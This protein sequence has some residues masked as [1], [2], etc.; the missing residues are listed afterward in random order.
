MNYS[1]ANIIRLLSAIAAFGSAAMAQGS[2][3]EQP[4]SPVVIELFSSQSCSACITAAEYFQELALRD[5]IV[6]L[7]WHVD[8]WNLL[9]TRQGRWE[10]PYSRKEH[11][12]RQKKYN[13]NIRKRSSVYTPQMVVDG[14]FEA[15]GSSREK[16]SALI[17]NAQTNHTTSI[18][19]ARKEKN[20]DIFFIVGRSRSGG[21]AYFV[22][23]QRSIETE[24]KGGENAGVDFIDANVVTNVKRLGVVQRAGAKIIAEPP[25]VGK[26]CA[27]LIQEP[28]Q[29][30]IIAASYCP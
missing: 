4:N 13:I 22:T 18:I 8:Y 23:F 10:D 17:S 12:D 24:I 28:G 11:T 15:V 2:A 27:L 6:A 20:G 1:G 7:G 14:S 19:E 5:D 26:G 9:N 21:N 25:A 3:E 16:V 30:R 29:R